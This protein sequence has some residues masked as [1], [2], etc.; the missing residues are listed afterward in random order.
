[1]YINGQ[2]KFGSSEI[3]SGWIVWCLIEP[4]ASTQRLCIN[5]INNK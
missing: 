4:N 3:A 2:P 5:I 1:M